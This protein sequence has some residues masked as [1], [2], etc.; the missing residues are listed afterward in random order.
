VAAEGT[1][2][3]RDDAD[4]R[5][6][7]LEAAVA[8]RDARIAEHEAIIAKLVAQIEELKEKLNR[9]SSNSH[10]PPSSDRPGSGGSKGREKKF[11]KRK[12]GG[13]KGRRGAHRVLLPAADIDEFIDMFPASCE[14]CGAEL[15]NVV[16][17]APRRYQVIELLVGKRHIA[18][19][20]R[21]EVGCKR[22]GQRTLAAYDPARIPASPFGPQL[23]ARVAM[24]TGAYHLSRR[25]TRQLLRELFGIEISLGSISAMEERA[26]AALK[27]A[28]EEAECAVQDVDVKHTDATS[29]LRAGVTKSL[30]TLASTTITVYKILADGQRDTIRSLFGALKGILVSDRTKVLSFWAMKFRQICWAH[31]MRKFV[32]FAE[33]DGP[34]GALGR[35]LLDYTALV[36][37]CWHA[38]KSGTLDRE[39][40][41]ASMRPVQLQFEAAL[42]R[43]VTANILRLSGSCTDILAHREALWTFVT[44]DGVDPTNNLAERA[45][46]GFVLWRKR[47]FGCQSERGEQFAERVMTVVQTLRQQGRD[48]LDFLVRSLTAHVAGAVAPALAS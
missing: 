31:L 1:N 20:R 45:L 43:A 22:C 48:V 18:E 33:R 9:N 28:F 12:R 4:A 44:H 10:L 29:W 13:Q 19:F 35:E 24:L 40:L 37:D 17:L 14:G 23:I 7:E 39:Q 34:A 38:F 6:T 32:S 5:V 47:S 15:P 41:V 8:E 3:Q 30:W 11:G 16:D 42:E 46:R 25:N 2:E 27:P 36:F 26:S 21:H